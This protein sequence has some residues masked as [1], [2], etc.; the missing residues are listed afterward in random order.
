L[1]RSPGF[2]ADEDE[3]RGPDGAREAG[4]LGEEAVA[5]WTALPPADRAAADPFDIE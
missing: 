2:R 5:G 3:A 4:V 1:P